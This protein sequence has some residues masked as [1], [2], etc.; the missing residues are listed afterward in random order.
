MKIQKSQKENIKE[1]A[2]KMTA[3]KKNIIAFSN[4]EISKKE[5]ND[6]GIKL[7]MPL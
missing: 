3:A 7:T 1:A 2:K 4:K 6:R 5:L